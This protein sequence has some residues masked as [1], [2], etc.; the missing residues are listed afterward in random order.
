MRR[1][2][3]ALAACTMAMLLVAGPAAPTLAA[4][5]GGPRIAAV[6]NPRADLISGGD[7]LVRVTGTDTTPTFTVDGNA[8]P[9]VAHAQ[10][11]GSWLALVTGM[12]EGPHKIRAHAGDHHDDLKVDNHPIT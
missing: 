11:D 9:A 2:A 3:G 10:P 12:A 4:P 6:S 8:N 1:S 5:E 7:I